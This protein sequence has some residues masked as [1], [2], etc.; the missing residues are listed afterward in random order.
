MKTIYFVRHGESEANVSGGLIG[1]GVDSRLTELGRRQSEQAGQRL[2]DKDIQLI[3]CSPKIRALDTANI[4]AAQIGYDPAKIIQSEMFGERKYGIY[5]GD[6]GEPQSPYRQDLAAGKL[7]KS[8]E[9]TADIYNRARACMDWLNEQ[10][11]QNIVLVGHGWFGRMINLI[12]QSL[13]HDEFYDTAKM[14]NGQIF[15]FNL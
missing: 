2:K 9:G 7:D 12:Q 3:V 10:P 15:E 6:N 13:N 4:I 14:T 8:A 11:Q 5:E 1:V